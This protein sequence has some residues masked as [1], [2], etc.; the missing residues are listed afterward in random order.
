MHSGVID[1][2][3]AAVAQAGAQLENDN[4]ELWR[5]QQLQDGSALEYP[6]SLSPKRVIAGRSKPGLPEGANAIEWTRGY[7]N[8]FRT[9]AKMAKSAAEMT[10]ML[11][12]RKPNAVGFPDSDGLFEMSTEV[13][14]GEIAPVE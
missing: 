8:D 3:K 11:R 1:L 10:D 7:I 12:V 6:E 5:K 4:T 2:Q 14:T 13:A 9:F